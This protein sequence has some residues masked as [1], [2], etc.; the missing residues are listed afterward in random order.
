MIHIQHFKILYAIAESIT[1][2]IYNLIYKNRKRKGIQ[3]ICNYRPTVLLYFFIFYCSLDNSLDS[4]DYFFYFFHFPSHRYYIDYINSD[5]E[6]NFAIGRL[7]GVVKVENPLDWETTTEY[8]V[9]ILA[10]DSGEISH[11]SVN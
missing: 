10:V 1:L 4:F 8:S 11:C 7:T 9:R 6:R 3:N 2:I 5:P